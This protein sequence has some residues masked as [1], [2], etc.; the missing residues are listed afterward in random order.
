MKDFKRYTIGKTKSISIR[1]SIIAILF[2]YQC[3]D[4]QKVGIQSWL[5]IINTVQANKK[6]ISD[7]LYSSEGSIMF[8]KFNSDLVPYTRKQAP[9]VLTTYLQLSSN[10]RPHLFRSNRIGGFD[11][12]RFQ[13]KYKDIKVEDGIYTVISKEDTIESMI[14]EFYQIP[15]SLSS[16]PK[17][18]Q[19]EM[20]AKALQHFKAKRY[21]W[22]VP[23]REYA[24][25]V[26]KND[27]KATYYPKGELLIYQ[28]SEPKPNSKKEFRL[29]Y[30]FGIAA[31]EPP[32][33]KYVYVDSQSGEI[34]ASK[35]ARRYEADRKFDP[36]PPQLFPETNFGICYPDKTPCIK[37][38]Y[39]STRFSGVKS[40]TT[41]TAGIN[42]Y[43]ELKDYSRG[44]GIIT[45]SWEFKNLP[46]L[47]IQFL[48]SPTV[49]TDNYWSKSEYHDDY[50][51][52]ALFDAHWGIEKTYDYFKSVHDRSSYDDEDGK[53]VNNVHYFELF[54]HNNAFW[55]PITEELYYLYCPHNSI[56][57][58]LD[59]PIILD[60]R[61][62]DFT[63]LDITSHEFGHGVNAH[64]AGFKYENEP[65]ALD[66]GFSDI[67]NI[68]VNHFV[69]KTLGMQK[70]IWLMGDET[71]PGGGIRSAE[72]P[73]STT[74][75]EPG[76]TTY[77]GALWD[78][79]KEEAHTNSN[80]LS[81]WFYI[82]SNGK[83]WINDHNCAYDVSGISIEKAEKIAYS[84]IHS[85]TPTSGYM[86]ARS[87]TILTS[88]FLYGE[89][90]SEV[91]N[92]IDAW[93]AVGVPAQTNSR[94]GEGM[95]KPQHFITSV[96]LSNLEKNSGNDCGYKDNTYLRPTVLKGFTY[97]I[98]LS[99]KGF[100]SFPSRTHRWRV[101]ID[102]D[103]DGNFDSSEIV[104]QDSIYSSLG[105]TIQKTIT[106]PSNVLTGNTKMR[107]S[108]KAGLTSE[109]YPS[110]DEFFYEG[111]VEDYTI[112][113]SNFNL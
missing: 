106:I 69:N 29:A 16:S 64:T 101:W 53:V 8:A 61:F 96:K 91:K 98:I 57:K 25:K 37:Q 11:Y 34:L 94:G 90:S 39:A 100:L 89:F 92:T 20:L 30:K 86:S 42:D 111:E 15:E 32:A 44:K 112:T 78:F 49:D 59:L 82:L 51:H 6:A 76:P 63:S 3:N 45:Y 93:D 47:G 56:C 84:A 46:L 23:E 71:V 77:K 1:I 103:R 108:M 80:V 27:P 73:K 58:S 26:K 70:N 43:Y 81:H 55:D 107:V 2:L 79:E 22:E 24:L 99:S 68:G 60:P 13:Q 62:E 109:T 41:W 31:V 97:S 19:E 74:I 5:G 35:D 17:L 110:A 105:G 54:I 10:S 7:R 85:L 83:Q 52:D 40:I 65:A 67:W 12:D 113:I 87:A 88:K 14:G 9:E 72:N 38:G 36:Q 75:S 21:A 50:N 48:N 104:V 4:R 33:S 66:E 18:S 95:L 102:F 28:Y